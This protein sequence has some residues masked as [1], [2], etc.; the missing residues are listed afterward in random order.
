[1]LSSFVPSDLL[2]PAYTGTMLTSCFIEGRFRIE[3][4]LNAR[5][6]TLSTGFTSGRTCRTADLGW[7]D[8]LFILL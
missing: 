3:L 2:I 5:A 7:P 1:M 6:F 8:L 4:I